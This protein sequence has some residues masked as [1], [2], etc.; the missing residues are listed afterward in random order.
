MSDNPY[1]APEQSKAAA[2]PIVE[3][4]EEETL[5]RQMIGRETNI[6]TMAILIYIS[7]VIY[8]LIGVVIVLYGLAIFTGVAQPKEDPSGVFG[9]LLFGGVGALAFAFGYWQWKGAEDLRRLSRTGCAA[10]TVWSALN[11]INFPVGTVLGVAMLVFMFDRKGN[12]VLSPEYRDIIDKTPHIRNRWSLLTKIAIGLLVTVVV[13]VIAA[14]L[15]VLLVEGP[16][17]FEK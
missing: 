8:M 16:S 1:L 15:L 4:S 10:G 12:F 13:I 5:R 7:S 17:G 9:L 6:R 2:A 3:Q 11:L 14:M